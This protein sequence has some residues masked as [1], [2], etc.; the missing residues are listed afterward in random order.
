[1][2]VRIVLADDHPI[3]LDGL[4]SIIDKNDNGFHIIYEASNG[5]E[6]LKFAENSRA[7]IYV[8]DISM[9]I[10]NGI[11]TAAK[12][13]KMD[14]GNKILM[15]SFHDKRHLVEQ[16]FQAGARGYILKESA[17]REV[18]DAIREVHQGRF[19]LSP[20]ISKYVIEG[21]LGKTERPGNSSETASLTSR[22]R[23]VLQLIG[24]GFSDKQISGLLKL[25]PSTVHVHR[26]NIMFKLGMHKQAELIRYAIKEGIS[27][28]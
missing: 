4:R 3:V 24:E 10:L 20:A 16:A 22:E 6:V 5:Q 27:K 13:I 17:T 25:S 15:L 14:P 18:V 1:M 7:D 2:S 26:K 9:P 19:Y 12:L 23:E 28:L 11:E 21:F 8:L